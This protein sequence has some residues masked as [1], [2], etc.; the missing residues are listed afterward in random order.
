MVCVV[1]VWLLVF[2]VGGHVCPPRVRMM[3]YYR[4]CVWFDFV[5]GMLFVCPCFVWLRFVLFVVCLFVSVMLN[6]VR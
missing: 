3:Y 2:R 5:S 4:C 6:C 1:F